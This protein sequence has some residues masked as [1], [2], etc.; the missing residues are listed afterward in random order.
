MFFSSIE[1]FVEYCIVVA[2]TTESS[3]KLLNDEEKKVV[4]A[5][6]V[7][8]SASIC[9]VV[10]YQM[11]NMGIMCRMGVVEHLAWPAL[12]ITSYKMGQSQLTTSCHFCH[13][14]TNIK[15][16]RIKNSQLQK[17]QSIQV[18]AGETDKIPNL[19]R[20]LCSFDRKKD[21]STFSQT[22]FPPALLSNN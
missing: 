17:L 14:L 12:L 19:F 16:M 4:C 3:Y 13:I 21:L 10:E 18:L 8:A 1:I 22:T 7:P 9:A 20:L 6:T 11:S 5:V 15:L 2:L